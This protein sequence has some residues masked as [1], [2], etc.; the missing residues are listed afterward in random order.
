MAALSRRGSFRAAA[1]ATGCR[2][3]VAQP[4]ARWTSTG[5]LIRIGRLAAAHSQVAASARD[6]NRLLSRQEGSSCSP[7]ETLQTPAYN[8]S[9]GKEPAAEGDAQ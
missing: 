4:R 5:S 7:K 3:R 2:P 8:K 6:E 1:Q 9:G